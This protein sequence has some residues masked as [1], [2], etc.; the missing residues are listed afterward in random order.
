MK[1]CRSDYKSS[2]SW[3][4]E[5]GNMLCIPV[6]STK[7]I[8]ILAKILESDYCRIDLAYDDIPSS[9]IDSLKKW[10]DKRN[11]GEIKQTG[12]MLVC[13]QLSKAGI[14]YVHQDTV[15]RILI[16]EEFIIADEDSYNDKLSKSQEDVVKSLGFVK[17]GCM[18]EL[19]Y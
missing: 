11:V 9:V 19:R 13:Q 5:Y 4:D 16:K 8:G 12:D 10:I 14:R 18:W 1:N 17:N 3:Y 2:E 7:E 15:K 6:E